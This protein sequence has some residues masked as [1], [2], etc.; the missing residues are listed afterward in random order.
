VEWSV[1]EAI[2]GIPDCNQD[3]YIGQKACRTFLFSPNDSGVVQVRCRK[4]AFLQEACL[5]LVAGAVWV[6]QQ[7]DQRNVLQQ[8]HCS[9][10]YRVCHENSVTCSETLAWLR[11]VLQDIVN[12]IKATNTPPIPDDKVRSSAA[13]GDSLN[14][15]SARCC[16]NHQLLL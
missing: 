13:C 12:N 9:S 10:H 15:A 1:P 16:V 3:L 8:M 6:R 14:S 2:D 7:V 11:C 4:K 5:K